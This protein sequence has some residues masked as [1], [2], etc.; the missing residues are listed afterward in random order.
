MTGWHFRGPWLRRSRRGRG[1][2]RQ[3][4]LSLALGLAMAFLLI[5]WFNTSL[6]P[7]LVALTEAQIRNYLTQTADRSLT[8]ALE[9]DLSYRD[10]VTLQAGENGKPVA[11]T[12]DTLHLNRLRTA[13]LDDIIVQVDSLDDHSL[14]VPLGTLTGID[15]LSALGPRL[16]VKVISVASVEGTF[17]NDFLSGGI[18]QTLH[19]VILDVAMAAKLLLPGG[20][21]E[22]TVS[23]PVCVAETVIVGQVPQTYV[24]LNK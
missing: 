23:V 17:R 15:L 3:F 21:V 5:R 18:N 1:E 4:V 9:E 10:M 24:G 13:V 6:R 20:V 11:L 12:T 2:K 8:R 22:I 14:S 7:Q 19:R 16:P